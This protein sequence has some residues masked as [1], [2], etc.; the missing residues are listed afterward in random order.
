MQQFWKEGIE[1]A[2][3]TETII[4]VGMRGDG[5]EPMTQGTAIALLERIVKDQRR[6]I[7]ESTG[8][9][10]GAVP[11]LWALYKE[12]Q[13]YYDKGMRVPDDITLLL[14]DDNWGNIRRLPRPGAAP[15]KGGYGIYYHFDY[16]GG[17]RNYKWINTNNLARVWEQMHLAWEHGVKKI[18]IV[19]VGDIKPME[20]PISFFIDYSWDPD[21]WDEKNI[22]N[23]YTAWAEEQF[24]KGPSAQIGELL[25]RYSQLAARRKPELLAP[26]TFHL[27]HY[28]EGMRVMKEWNDLFL[29]A[30]DFQTQIPEAAVEAYFQLVLHPITAYSNLVQLYH[31]VAMNRWLAAE[32]LHWTVNIF[33]DDARARYA[34]DSLLT[35][36]YHTRNGGKWNHMM[37]QTHIGYTYWQQPTANRMPG[38]VQ[39]NEDSLRQIL[40]SARKAGKGQALSEAASAQAARLNRSPDSTSFAIEAANYTRF[41]STPGLRWARIPGIGRT[42]DGM[43]TLPSTESRALNGRSPYL[44]YRFDTTGVDSINLHL[45]FSPTLNIYGNEGLRFALSVDGSTPQVFYL[46][47]N[48]NQLRTWESW[49]ANN[50]IIQSSR[51]RLNRTGT[52]TIRYWMIDGGVVLQKLVLDFGDL[53]PSYLGPP[54]RS[55]R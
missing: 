31:S 3:G 21:R 33:G 40:E 23:Y 19:N 55:M 49:V 26:E 25:Q 38:L 18:W 20:L 13:D 43:T 34:T 37:A 6:I 54:E 47:K 11:Q 22:T 27:Q 15:R 48:D 16:V 1:R 12:V 4:S 24:G 51:Y 41:K 30:R 5:D 14:C 42:G 32:G 53:K 36:D 17:P 8:K 2:K 52:H 35:I 9:P 39:V 45:H 28:G 7:E 44:E 46:N 29:A 10:A 50:I